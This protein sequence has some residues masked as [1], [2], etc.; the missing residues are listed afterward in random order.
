MKKVALAC[1]H[2]GVE[3]KN[4]IMVVLQKQGYAII[5]VGVNCEESI[6]YPDIVLPF[7]QQV[8]QENVLGI[9]LCGTGIGVSISANKVLG[10]RAALC[11]NEYTARMS[12]MH[13]DANVLAMGARVLGI[14]VAIAITEAFLA[15]EFSGGRHQRRIDKI[16]E[17]EMNAREG[18]GLK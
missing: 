3:L 7:C 2:T 10:I 13:N 5:D 16:S 4:T 8:L 12:R 9:I 15:T 14:E 6:D 1:D 11:H 17:L 18:K